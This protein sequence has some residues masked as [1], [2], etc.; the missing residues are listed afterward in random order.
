MGRYADAQS[1]L[2]EGLAIARELGDMERVARLLQPLALAALGQGNRAAAQRYCEEGLALAREQGDRREIAAALSAL[3]QFHRSDGALALAQPL[4]E[5]VL[6]IV[7]ELGDRESIGIT[8]LNLAMVGVGRGEPDRARSLLLEVLAIGTE[9]GSRP[10]LQSLIEVSAGFATA[11]GRYRDGAYFFGI[12][13]AQNAL[14]GMSRDPADEAFL[15]PLVAK[16]RQALGDASAATVERDGA[17]LSWDRALA[18]VRAFL[19]TPS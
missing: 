12:A 1:V 3:A 14:T 2:E 6:A 8:L 13:E 7:R 18:V 16:A 17:T 10:V 4:Y 5:Q 11:T 9:T 15:Q 19:E